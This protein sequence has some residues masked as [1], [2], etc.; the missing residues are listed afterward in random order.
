MIRER[1]RELGLATIGLGLLLLL[2]LRA[3]TSPLTRTA[4]GEGAPGLLEFLLIPL[5]LAVVAV[6][7]GL[8]LWEPEP[9]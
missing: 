7:I 4:T 1:N 8:A 6:G 3:W 9:S 5:F 2:G